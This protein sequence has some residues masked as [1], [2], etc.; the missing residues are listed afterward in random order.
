MKKPDIVKRPMV[1]IVIGD[2]NI[3]SDIIEK[4]V[5]QTF[6]NDSNS[7]EMKYLVYSWPEHKKSPWQIYQWV[8]SLADAKPAHKDIVIV[9]RSSILY[10][11]LAVKFYDLSFADKDHRIHN[12]D[13]HRAYYSTFDKGITALRDEHVQD[14]RKI[15]NLRRLTN[16]NG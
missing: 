1:H 12:I 5:A 16:Q 6:N 13:A 10:S 8:E 14:C 2:D 3:N 4:Y 11:R 15:L 9:T 7:G